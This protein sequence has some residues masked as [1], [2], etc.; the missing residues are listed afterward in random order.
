M[1]KFYEI[2]GIQTNILNSLSKLYYSVM[3]FT[4]KKYRKKHSAFI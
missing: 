3:F 4:E 2:K 1:L